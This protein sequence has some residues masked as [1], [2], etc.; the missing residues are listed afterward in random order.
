MM[1]MRFVCFS[2][3][4]LLLCGSLFGQ[5]ATKTGTIY[6]KVVDEKEV[7]LPNV[8]VLLESDV[9]P[10]QSATTGASGAF[11]FANL[12]PGTYAATFSLQ[13]FTEVRQE[14]LRVT[15]GGN[16]ELQIILKATLAEQVQ[17]VS[18]TPLVDKTKTGT[19]ATY[20]QEHLQEIPGGRDP[21]FIIDQTPGV[22]SDT[23]NIGGSESGNQSIFFARGGSFSNTVWNYDGVNISTGGSAAFYDFDAFEEMEISTGGNDAS[24][25]TGGVVVNIVTKR[26]GNNWAFNAS[27]YNVND[28]L[29]ST[30][31]PQELIDNPILNPI[32]GEPAKGSNRTNKINEYGLDVGG[33]AV[34]DKLFVWGAYRQNRI[35]QFSV[36]DIP[37]N[38][39]LTNY[40]LKAN[41][42]WNTANQSEF[43]YFLSYKDKI[44]RSLFPGNQAPETLWNQGNSHTLPFPGIL[45]AQQTWVPNDHTI[46]T[47]RYG[48]IGVDFGL[49]PPGGKDKPMIFL[50]KIPHWENTFYFLSPTTN[51]DHDISADLNSFKE[52][53]IGG[54]HEFKF[55]FEYRT[56]RVR[57]F[58]SYGNGVLITDY[59]QTTP[60]GPLTSGY[61]T[62]QHYVDGRQSRHRLSFYASDTYRR[63]RLTLNLGFHFDNQTGKNEPSSIPAVPGFEQFVGQFDYPGGDPGITFRGISPRLG[64]TYDLTGNGRTILRANFARYYDA[65]DNAALSH[66]N[67]TYVFSGAVFNYVNKNGDRT[68]TPDELVGDPQYYGGLTPGGVFDLDAFLASRKYAP[69]ISTPWTN[70][71]ILGA[72]REISKDLSVSVTYTFRRYGN[73]TFIDPFGVSTSDFVPGGIFTTTTPLGDFNV[74][75]FVLGFIHDGTAI[76]TNVK[77]YSQTYN[78]VDIV[79]KKR[80]SHN[81]QLNGSLTVQKQKGH[82]NG[83]D[84]LGNQIDSFF[85]AFDPTNLPFFQDR[86]YGYTG[87]A[88]I[89]PYSEWNLKI[90][91]VYQFPREIHVAAYLRYQQGYPYVLAGLFSDPRLLKFYGTPAHRIML[92]PFASRRF[93][94]KFLVD[95][96]F[97]KDFEIG[98]FGRI[99]GIVDLFNV[100]NSNTIIRRNRL[101]GTKAFNQ[102]SEV[103]S[104]RAVRLGIRYS[105]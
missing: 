93:D 31:T 39:K 43:G 101:T 16:I 32:T 49:I 102:I 104:P 54:D 21:W 28:A 55:G 81:F 8:T 14:E 26:G 86:P 36:A 51:R 41:L 10:S 97:E 62:A 63:D 24:T 59:F 35:N 44:G 84:S 100:T 7:P 25:Y 15:V 45:T 12:P 17:V 40:N 6:G 47:A 83:G 9:I 23:Y 66:S 77:D 80:M 88:G 22:E 92:E 34:K 87:R 50:S 5:V 33:P 71:I 98:R 74:P 61:L 18:E 60:G 99:T 2:L 73:F 46:V 67:P 85:Q 90:S 95:L 48:Y 68:I 91:G 96:K 38:T 69:D 11:R 94:N 72:E 20:T 65:F 70:E 78:G 3:G 37:D 30:N 29:Q 27:Y 82:Y 56:S 58:S 57:T 13:G 89:F 105:F 52:G 1:P 53:W 19:N 4:I 103:L 75:Y 42:N 79:V 76:Y 64:A